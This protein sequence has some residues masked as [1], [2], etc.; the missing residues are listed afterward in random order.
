M[1]SERVS[2]SATHMRGASPAGRETTMQILNMFP[3][4]LHLLPQTPQ[5]HFL[6]T[7]IRNVETQRTDFVFYSERIMR[8]IL[9][10]ALCMIPV[11]PFNVVTPTGAVYKGVRPDDRGI[12][13][14]S[15]MRAGESMERVLREMCR[16]V[17]IGKIL[18]QRDEASAD[19]SPDARFSYS[20]MPKDVASRRVLL[21][22][23]MCATG[24]SAIK[25]T[26]ILINEYDVLEENIIFLNLVSAPAGI[27]RYLSRFPKIQIV[28]AAIDDDLDEN[29]Y[30]LPG[31]GDFGDRYFGTIAD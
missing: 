17:R 14:V 28:T 16:G 29:M 31:L 26:E 13:G 27:K 1:A 18:V 15:I 12:I 8:L 2:T 7:V 11:E 24:G 20:K 22:D 5:L 19:K 9:E 6:F 10:A 30:I 25:A 3:G 4:H 21:L 23:P